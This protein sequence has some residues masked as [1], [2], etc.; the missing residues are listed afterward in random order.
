MPVTEGHKRGG[1]SRV[2]NT[3][4]EG[5]RGNGHYRRKNGK[6]RQ[7]QIYSEKTRA[8]PSTRGVL[9]IKLERG[10]EY[11][12]GAACSRK[13]RGRLLVEEKGEPVKKVKKL[14]GKQLDRKVQDAI[15]AGNLVTPVSQVIT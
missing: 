13:K 5:R 7:E 10:A 1:P 6:V 14:Q 8:L 15:K 11:A 3:K 9:P 4:G 12:K 2:H